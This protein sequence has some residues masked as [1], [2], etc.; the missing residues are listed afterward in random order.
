MLYSVSSQDTLGR[1]DLPKQSVYGSELITRAEELG[2]RNT[3]H[4]VEGLDPTCE[5]VHVLER[6]NKELVCCLASFSKASWLT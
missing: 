1:G 2:Q 4:G 3:I 6:V 5:N